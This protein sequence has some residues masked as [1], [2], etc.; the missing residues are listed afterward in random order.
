VASTP[1]E[2]VQAEFLERL[3]PLLRPGDVINLE[4]RPAWWAL[5]QQATAWAIRSRQRRLF[6][7]LGRTR[8]TH[9]LLLLRGERLLLA[10]PPRARLVPLPELH[11]TRFSVWRLATHA[12]SPE[13]LDELEAAAGR[14]LDLAFTPEAVFALAALGIMGYQRTLPGSALEPSRAHRASAVAVR[15]C[16]ER[17][18]RCFEPRGAPTVPRLFQRVADPTW[19]DHPA[20]QASNLL[21]RGLDLEATCPAHFS[22]SQ[23][24]ADEFRLVAELDHGIA[25]HP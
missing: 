15:A 19:L 23:R 13:E 17:V 9:S 21:L 18:R 4:A 25:L 3:R 6:G 1:G 5:D 20:V 2:Q 8:E 12:L 24:Y 11:A 14:F 10:G 22:N 16:L 7:P